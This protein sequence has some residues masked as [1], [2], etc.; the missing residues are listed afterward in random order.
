MNPERRSVPT[1]PRYQ[2]NRE[3][4]HCPVPNDSLEWREQRISGQFGDLVPPAIVPSDVFQCRVCGYCCDV[5]EGQHL[6]LKTAP[7]TP[8][9]RV[10]RCEYPNGK[11]GH[12]WEMPGQ[13]VAFHGP[14]LEVHSLSVRAAPSFE[15]AIAAADAM[16]CHR[17]TIGDWKPLRKV[18]AT[19]P[20]LDP[21]ALA[22]HRRQCPQCPEHSDSLCWKATRTLLVDLPEG[23][24]YDGPLRVGDLYQ[25]S[26]CGYS[27][28]KARRG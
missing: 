20:A 23:W 3:C 21:P 18:E 17:S 27:E 24:E 2:P 14:I 5:V 8:P 28:L 7:S 10:W 15:Q 13:Y 19:R 12:V 11:S 4:P 25:C 26:S 22:T 6:I 16:A 1:P 9:L